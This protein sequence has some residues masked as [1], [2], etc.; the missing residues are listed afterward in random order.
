MLI[1]FTDL[2]QIDV[3]P[4]LS[5]ASESRNAII[6]SKDVLFLT[7]RNQCNYFKMTVIAYLYVSIAYFRLE[8]VA[9]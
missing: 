2:Y 3:D 4:T 6:I 8:I 9:R 5:L 7:C 1:V